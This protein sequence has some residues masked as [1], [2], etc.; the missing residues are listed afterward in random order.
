MQSHDMSLLSNFQS[1]KD[2]STLFF[3]SE[4]GQGWLKLEYREA[5]CSEESERGLCDSILK[6]VCGNDRK[7]YDNECKLCY[8]NKRYN[9]DVRIIRAG[10]CFLLPVWG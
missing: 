2:A 3:L 5:K 4:T 6:P 7:T 1:Q 9:K 10:E 8:D